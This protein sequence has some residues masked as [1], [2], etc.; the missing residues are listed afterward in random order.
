MKIKEFKIRK[1][2]ITIFAFFVITSCNR[3]TEL[4]DAYGTFEADEVTVSSEVNGKIL[5]SNIDEGNILKESEIVIEIDSS[6]L[7]IKKEQLEAQKEAIATKLDNIKTQ[8]DVQSQQKENIM[9]DKMRIDK[10]FKDGAATQKQMDDINSSLKLIDKQISSIESQIKSVNA[11]LNTIDKQVVQ[12]NIN[13]GK[14][15]VI[16]PITGIVLNKFAEVGELALAGKALYKIAKLDEIT[17]RVYIS[18]DMINSVKLNQKVK[19]LVDKNQVEN[20]ELEGT[21][22]WIASS[23][24]FTPKIIQTKEER[25]NLVYAVKVKV[26]NDGSLKIGMPGEIK[27]K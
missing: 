14:T 8:I 24:E 9:I 22:Y 25:V 5:I 12:V 3:N 2:I 27:L 10:M 6:D 23:A 4:S 18:G 13:L 26:K 21:I 17:L 15:H 19:V 16:N 20:T 7:I 1:L 11:E